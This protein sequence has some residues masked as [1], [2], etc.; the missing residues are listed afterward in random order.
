MQHLQK[1]QFF[2]NIAI[3][4]ETT[5]KESPASKGLRF[6]PGCSIKLLSNKI[7]SY[8]ILRTPALRNLGITK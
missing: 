1:N 2:H 3:S 5:K 8:L 6:N 4:T 7:Q